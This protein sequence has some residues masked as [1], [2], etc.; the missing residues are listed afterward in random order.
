MGK[1]NRVTIYT[2]A[3][4]A[5]V[6]PSTVSR[7]VNNSGYIK[8][9]TRQKVITAMNFL[10]YERKHIQSEADKKH[11]QGRTETEVQNILFK[12]NSL[13]S[14]QYSDK[15]LLTAH[16][17]SDIEL[18]YVLAG[19]VDFLLGDEN[20]RLES[21][22]F[23][24]INHNELHSFKTFADTLYVSM[25]INYYGLCRSID[26]TQLEIS[27]NTTKNYRSEYES[28][29][30]ILKKIFNCR[31]TSEGTGAL[32]LESL[33]YQLL[34]LLVSR[35][36]VE[37]NK[38]TRDS[39]F[40]EK[41]KL[42]EI[43]QYI[44][45]NYQEPITL[46]DLATALYFSPA[47]MSK[48]FKKHFNMSF[49]A[50]LCKIRLE[51]AV[52][53]LKQ[54]DKS[55]TRIAMDN[56]FP[57]T[58]SFNKAFFADYGRTPSNFIKSQH[59]EYSPADAKIDDSEKL[60]HRI[61]EYLDKH[62]WK[63]CNRKDVETDANLYR[64]YTKY[65][66]KMI[67]I[68][69][70]DL[71]FDAEMQIQLIMMKKELGFEY[72]RFWDLYEPATFSSHREKEIKFYFSKLDRLFDFLIENDL[73][74]FIELGFKPEVLLKLTKEGHRFVVSKQ[75]DM[76]FNTA[77]EYEQFIYQFARHYSDRFGMENFEKW[78]FE[79]WIDPRQ[80]NGND[81]SGYFDFFEAAYRGLK[82]VSK[83]IKIGG[84]GISVF[85][86]DYKSLLKAWHDRSAC[87]D[88]FSI[89]Y[90][91]YTDV[92]SGSVYQSPLEQAGDLRRATCLAG[93][94]DPEIYVTEWNFTVSDRNSFN[95]R[96]FKA[97][98]IV[99]TILKCINQLDIMGYWYISDLQS[100]YT[101]SELILNG[102]NGLIS[103][104]GL[105]KPA[106]YSFY[107]FNLLENY[108][109]YNDDEAIVTTD[110][111]NGY[112]IMCHNFKKL[113]L[114]YFLKTED[115]HN[116]SKYSDFYEN[117]ED[118]Q[119]SFHIKNATK[120]TYI[121]KIHSVSEENGNIYME[122]SHMGSPKQLSNSE[123]EYLKN[124]SV[125]RIQIIQCEVE[126]NTLSIN[127]VLTPQEVQYIHISL[128]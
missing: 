62:R 88:F 74:P 45:T 25:Y 49:S 109:L 93:F 32:Y 76:L 111:H 52:E 100:E 92:I 79:Q 102:G 63:N 124:I 34:N 91:P 83:D 39:Q 117:N 94:K 1:K 64:P 103:R 20:F 89:Y 56:G 71:L 110:G 96:C 53:N 73:L 36:A 11:E 81:F 55:I 122:W 90:Y 18:L 97:A 4:E 33:Y 38:Y 41:E 99:Q 12:S 70:S 119:F 59:R 60:F 75:S 9:A 10:G 66:N 30:D 31:F 82:R 58:S 35:F 8:I 43:E 98:F 48:Y 15:R 65:W 116:V 125:P 84:G 21:D 51:N 101:D 86:S 24:V 27:C 28:L 44:R 42:N 106:Y 61:Q 40:R 105:K 68:G 77:K 121:V 26:L 87:P 107:L 72:I 114:R 126:N 78:Y 113:D 128:L 108:L 67:N 29:Q 57:N 37:K 2:V 3:Q 5:G 120:G 112:S 19:T 17:H 95:D 123:L 13:I 16:Q 54:T 115:V 22:D 69:K 14:I 7:T 118:K 46:N 23:I 50:Y 104:D 6:S 80:I 127:T 47:Y 85:N